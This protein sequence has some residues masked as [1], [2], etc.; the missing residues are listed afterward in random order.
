MY[1]L[2]INFLILFFVFGGLGR[3]G[4]LFSGFRMVGLF[5]FY[6]FVFFG[7]V[8]IWDS[9]LIELKRYLRLGTLWVFVC[10]FLIGLDVV[11]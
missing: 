11:F 3:V 10:Y 8:G 4:V 6:L 5:V 1:G 2:L 9:D 7:M